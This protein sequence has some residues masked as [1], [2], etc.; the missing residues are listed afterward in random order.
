MSEFEGKWAVILGVTGGAGA[1]AAGAL[2]AQ[3]KLN[4]FGVH[5][6]N[7]PEEEKKVVARVEG[8][9]VKSCMRIADAGTAGDAAAGAAQL[10]ET[11]GPRSI[12][13]L[14]HATAN[15][16]YGTFAANP[17]QMLHPKQM[18]KTFDVMAHSFIYWVQEL[19][20]RD[21]LA[22]NATIVA[23]SNPMAD[24][25]VHGWGLIA[26]AKAALGIYVRQLADELGPLGHR[27]ML[28]KF[29]L[30]ETHAIRIAFSDAQ[31][32]ALKKRISRLV[33]YRRLTTVD[34]VADFICYAVGQGAEWFN[35]AAVDFSGGQANALL[36]PVFNPQDY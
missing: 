7:F 32:E 13:V 20:R 33:P 17:E 15:A 12:K 26:A 35:G 23:L 36:N 30:V 28:V 25:V 16:S 5:R 4:V 27:V 22:D 3:R 8:A 31:W 19:R 21:L 6:G 34:E 24:S 11:A 2:S 10:L 14:V 18:A 9:G 29:G 1:A